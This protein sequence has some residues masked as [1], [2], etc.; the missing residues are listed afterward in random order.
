M[1]TQKPALGTPAYA[2]F[3]RE[4]TVRSDLDSV[5]TKMEAAAQCGGS[6]IECGIDSRNIEILRKSGLT[7][8]PQLHMAG[9][10]K[11]S[12]VP[13]LSAGEMAALKYSNK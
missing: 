11:I 12:W 13:T 6:W 9:L 7:V 1:A 5:Q 8:E 3:L 10:Y 4:L 2:D